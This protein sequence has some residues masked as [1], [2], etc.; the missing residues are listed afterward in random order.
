M[1][2]FLCL[3]KRVLSGDTPDS[4]EVLVQYLDM[5]EQKAALLPRKKRIATHTHTLDTLLEVIADTCL[6]QHWRCLCLNYCYRPLRAIENLVVNNR[7][8]YYLR[9]QQHK[10]RVISHYFR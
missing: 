10:L 2:D 1:T 5:A 4:P 8:Q 7:E 9:R 6:P 3:E